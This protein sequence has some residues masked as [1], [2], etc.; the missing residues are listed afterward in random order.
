MA[1]VLRDYYEV[2]G[3]R[4]D[5]DADEIARAF[6]ALAQ[7]L[8]PEMSP[9]P[10]AAARFRELVE[11]YDV[12]SSRRSKL[13]YDRL[14]FRGLRSGGFV[15]G[16]RS[17]HPDEQVVAAVDVDFSRARDGTTATLRSTVTEP[18]PRCRGAGAEPGT[19]VHRCE[20][21]GGRGRTRRRLERGG[22]H[23][24]QLQICPACRGTG[25]RFVRPCRACSGSGERIV[26]RVSTVRVPPGVRNG[27]RLHVAGIGD[28]VVR[29]RP[30]AIDSLP[31]RL[32]A[33]AVLLAAIGILVYALLSG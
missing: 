30:R 19:E 28:V 20:R 2:L 3:V 9:E 7:E 1:Q 12:L 23:L 4:R 5:S 18:C 16:F 13:L 11:A 29:V 15:P 17:G 10:D 32:L 25:R 27:E 31:V 33:A 21:C 8:H 14:G 22:V 24:P 6:R 26:E